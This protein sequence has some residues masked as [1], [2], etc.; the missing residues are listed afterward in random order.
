MKLQQIANKLNIASYPEK[1]NDITDWGSV[2][3]ISDLQWLEEIENTYQVLKEYYPLVCQ[4]VQEL[5]RD[6]ERFQWGMTVAA[7]LTTCTVSQARQIPMP[8]RNNTLA[9]DFLPLLILLTQIPAGVEEYRRRKMPEDMIRRNLDHFVDG[10]S[11]VEHRTGS[12]AID[13]TYFNWLVKFVKATLFN[14]CGFNFEIKELSEKVFV[15]QDLKSGEIFPVLHDTLIHYSG[16][17]LNAAGCTETENS[18]CV[19]LTETGNQYIANPCINGLVSTESK[20]FPKNQYRLIL[21]PGETVLSVH[22]P[23][24][25]D[26]SVQQA[27]ASLSA[28]F[29]AAIK[30]YPE[31]DIKALYCR[32]WLL[33]PSLK[34]LLQPT[35]KIPQFGNMFTRYPSKSAGRE[36]FSFVFPQAMPLQQL[37][38]NTSL[39]RAVKNH[40]INGNHIL[41]Y[42]GFILPDQL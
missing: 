37:P 35:A 41:A 4:A 42:S 19:Q 18:F 26:I 12:P 7:Y 28:G 6:K 33:D 31:F 9:G 2:P 38:E 34:D 10:I 27:S 16:R 25:T 5:R 3:D 24:G 20:I 14:Y 30:Y 36:V 17:I 13:Q 40:Y 23:R 1:L 15:L 39:E 11:I 8:P 29:K 22:I 21:Q 32:S